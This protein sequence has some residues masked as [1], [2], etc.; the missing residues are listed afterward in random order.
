MKNL[1]IPLFSILLMI[2]GCTIEQSKELPPATQEGK[3]TFGCLVNGEVLEASGGGIFSSPIGVS[4]NY[5]YSFGARAGGIMQLCNDSDDY[6]HLY[7]VIEDSIDFLQQHIYNLKRSS[8]GNPTNYNGY[9]SLCD[10]NY[11]TF[12]EKS[13]EL[14]ITKLDT[15]EKIIAGTFWFDA[16]SEDEDIIEIREGRFDITYIPTRN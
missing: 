15:T 4:V 1:L 6:S 8:F 5:P 12:G 14:T 11:E 10:I 16:Q 7:L 3:N 13:G 2:T 9:V